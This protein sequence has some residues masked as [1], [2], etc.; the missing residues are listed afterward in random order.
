MNAL[1]RDENERRTEIGQ[2]FLS[3]VQSGKIIPADTIVRMLRKIIYSGDGRKKFILTS[4]PDIIDQA[5]EFERSCASI[6]AII[7]TTNEPSAEN[8]IIEIKNN[9]LTLFNI[10]ALFQKEH[11]L[12]TMS[13]WDDQKWQE[14]VGAG[15]KVEWSAVVGL[16]YQGKT[17]LANIL[18]KHLGFK[19]VDW[20]G[21]EEEVKKSLGTEDAPFE[22]VPPTPK[23]EDAVIKLIQADKAKGIKANYIFDSFPYH[24]SAAE[25]SAFTSS[26]LKSVNPDHLFDLR[27]GG[28]DQAASALRF[29]K[30]KEIEGDLSEEQQADFKKI[31][32]VAEVITGQFVESL[33]DAIEGG[34]VRHVTSLR[35]DATSEQT[36]VNILK[37][38]LKPRVIL[39]NHEKRLSVDTTCANLGI[40]YN[41]LYISV[42]QLIKQHIEENTSFGKT[43]VATKKPRAMLVQT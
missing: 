29:K 39:V 13:K 42:Y 40:K 15:S 7:Y 25:I 34:L 19:L 1:I 9:N 33:H 26:K 21:L 41:M 37:G 4:F 16:P 5:R 14:I 10:D 24:Q 20:K 11:R 36:Q 43:L 28:V 23:I 18:S 3:M 30:A 31:Y 27:K 2:E 35:T 8:P 22:G 12:K 17:Q 32:T 38:M 6:S